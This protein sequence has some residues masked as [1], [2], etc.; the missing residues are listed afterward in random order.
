MPVSR[1]CVVPLPFDM[2]VNHLPVQT[3]SPRAA[4]GTLPAMQLPHEDKISNYLVEGP[5][6]TGGCLCVSPFTAGQGSFPAAST[7]TPCPSQSPHKSTT[8][9]GS[10]RTCSLPTHTPPPGKC[11][12]WDEVVRTQTA[13]HFTF[14]TSINSPVCWALPL[15]P[16]VCFWVFL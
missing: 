6:L 2:T 14:C 13:L 5:A 15:A 8:T 11:W 16:L 7:D 12:G 10:S 1:R 3:H 4:Q 9:V